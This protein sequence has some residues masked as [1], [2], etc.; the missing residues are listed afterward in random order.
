MILKKVIIISSTFSKDRRGGVASYV[1]NRA[2]FLSK[3][4][5][6]IVCGLGSNYKDGNV[7]YKSIG[8]PSIF[9][10]TFLINWFR[11]VYFCLKQKDA[12]IEIH[13]IPIGLPLFFLFK[14]RYFFHGPARLEAIVEKRSRIQQN[15]SYMLEKVSLKRSNKIF[16]VSDNFR[17]VLKSEHPHINTRILKKLPVYKFNKDFFDSKVLTTDHLNF[18]IVR[19]L[20]KRTGVIE[21]V[22]L[23]ICSKP[24]KLI[25]MQF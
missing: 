20:V 18:I 5:E 1:D 23:F 15:I 2:L 6:V 13:N 11:L 9:R 22:K 8:E 14:N 7:V 25:R 19:R 4:V 21:F 24:K 3:E 17:G 12:I 16:V 10:Y